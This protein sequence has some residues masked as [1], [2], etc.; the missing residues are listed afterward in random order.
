MVHGTFGRTTS[1][2]TSPSGTSR[3]VSGSTS[4]TSNQ[5][6]TARP[7]APGG[8]GTPYGVRT[9]IET[10]VRPKFSTSSSIPKRALNSSCTRDGLGTAQAQRSRWSASSGRSGCF[11]RKSDMTPTRLVTVAPLSRSHVVHRLALNFSCSTS[12]APRIIAG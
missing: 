2:P 1:S 12:E 6:S 4:R 11:Q 7:A 9:G 10:S 5:S 3:S 8:R